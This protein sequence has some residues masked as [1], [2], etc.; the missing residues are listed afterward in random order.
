MLGLVISN[1]C[2]ANCF[3]AFL[4]A[5][6][7][8]CRQLVGVAFASD[9]GADDPQA[10]DAGDR[11]DDMMKLNVHERQRLLHVLD[12]RSRVVGMLLACAQIGP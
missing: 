1:Q 2:A 10:G 7:A 4:A 3:E 9:D 11:G 8:H 6:V 12:V 5:D